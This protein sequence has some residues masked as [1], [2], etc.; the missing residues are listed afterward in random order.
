MIVAKDGHP[1][2][3]QDG[4]RAMIVPSSATHERR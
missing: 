4:V 3:D 2:R 1:A